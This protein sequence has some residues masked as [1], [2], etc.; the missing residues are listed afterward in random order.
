MTTTPDHPRSRAGT[1]PARGLSRRTALVG[2]ALLVPATAG[3]RAVAA[4]ET[5]VP[6][7]GTDADAL[8]GLLDLEHLLAAM[9]DNALLAY[10][11][12]AF[13]AAGMPPAL[14]PN[15]EQVRDAEAAHVAAVTGHV[16]RLGGTAP[17]AAAYAFDFVSLD[18]FLKTAAT[19]ENTATAAYAGAIPLVRD[20]DAVHDLLGIHSVEA[21]HGTFLAIVA[22][23]SPVPDAIDLPMAADD[24]AAVLSPYVVGGAPLPAASP[25]T[26]PAEPTATPAPAVAVA[27]TAE[28]APSPTAP[29][30]AGADASSSTTKNKKNNKKDKKDKAS[31]QATPE[32]TATDASG[33]KNRKNDGAS[34]ASSPAPVTG[35]GG[36]DG[37]LADAASVF[38]IAADQIT[39]VTN[40]PRQWPDSSLGCPEPGGVYAQKITP[41]SVVLTQA[42]DGKRIEYHLDDAGTFVRCRMT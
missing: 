1:T 21:R 25:V 26:S 34:G 38:G 13:S 12:D 14:R 2:A 16:V 20:A 18:G 17:A 33:K 19:L 8:R 22:G 11:A 5:P 10:N 29:A 28:P 31:S 32:P 27:P 7:V 9:Y 37:A 41:G 35:S 30:N 36:L 23:G 39:V 6:A 3:L 40:E 24:V 42:P 4:Q 15:L